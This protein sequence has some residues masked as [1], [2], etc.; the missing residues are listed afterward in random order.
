MTLRIFLETQPD[1]GVV[2]LHGWLGATEVGE[3][4]K[5]VA[6]LGPSS[7]VDLAHLTGI[8]AEGLQ[9]LRRLEE[10]GTPLEGA[11]PYMALLLA[12]TAMACW[13]QPTE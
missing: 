4:E 1:G 8:D 7:R 5:A 3:V 10:N 2:A 6:E 9:A 13:G 11:S 12:S